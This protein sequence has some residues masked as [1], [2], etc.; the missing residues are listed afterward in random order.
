MS[1]S[2]SSLRLASAC[3][4]V[5]ILVALGRPAE[6]DQCSVVSRKQAD[7]AAD[8]LRTGSTNYV[9][10]CKP[11]GDPAPDTKSPKEIQIKP[12][13]PPK[14]NR[15]VE[16]KAAKGGGFT[17]YVNGTAIDLAYTFYN[18]RSGGDRDKPFTVY[19]NLANLV[20]CSAKDSPSELRIDGLLYGS[21]VASVTSTPDPLGNL[22]L[23]TGSWNV[24]VLTELSTC[25]NDVGGTK[26][27]YTWTVT[28]ANG[29]LKIK[30]S[31]G[32]TFT[33][34]VDSASKSLVIWNDANRS[35]SMTQLVANDAKTLTGRQIQ[36]SPTSNKAEPIC[37]SYRSIS[38]VKAN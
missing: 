15:A 16:V 5:L 1:A 2:R 11:C 22:S 9:T 4:S 20:G 32:A 38:A 3:A 13:L 28:T 34:Q 25:S 14:K 35:G 7:Q 8:V 27:S 6:A 29:Q 36:G 19:A 26:A 12:K 37:A 33:G 10:Y 31:S 17:V 30:S 18:Q 21:P 24:N 23:L